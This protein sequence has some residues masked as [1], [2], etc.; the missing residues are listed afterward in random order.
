VEITGLLK[1]G[2]NAIRVVVANLALN[3]L[4]KGPLPDYKEL[5]AKYGEKFQAQDMQSVRSLPA[6]M[7]APVR[8]VAR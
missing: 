5:N 1:P 7:L 4:A 6:G 2:D 3:V 8:L